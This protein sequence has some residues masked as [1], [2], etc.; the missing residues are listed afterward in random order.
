MGDTKGG[1]FDIDADSRPRCSPART[2]TAAIERR[3]RPA[4][5]QR[6]GHHGPAS[7]NMWIIDFGRRHSEQEAALYEAPFEYVRSTFNPSASK[8]R[9]VDRQWWLHVEPRPGCGRPSAGL[10]DTS[11]RPMPPSTGCSLA[12]ADLPDIALIAI[13]RG[14]RLH[15][16]RPP[17]ACPRA[18]G[19]R[20]T[21][22]QL[23]EVESGFRY[24][25]TTT[26]ETFPFPRPHG[27]AAR[28][29][30]GGRP[31]PRRAPR[32]LAQPARPRSRRPREAN[33]HQP[34]QPAPHLARPRPRRPSTP[35]SSP[36]TAGPHSGQAGASQSKPEGEPH[37]QAEAVWALA[38][39]GRGLSVASWVEPRL[40]YD[41]IRDAEY[42]WSVNSPTRDGAIPCAVG[43]WISP[44]TTTAK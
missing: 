4:V 29:S 10:A 35:P 23:R 39:R 7:R 34:L 25:P 40:K 44:R 38:G 28:E 41:M 42:A 43:P 26:F 14:R 18:L 2:P 9:T 20:D 30:R 24:T 8:R 36:P 12:A 17:L 22:T 27:R 37:L 32:R 16:R 21:G 31:P 11:R 1:P 5:G 6:P 19:A 3:R 13:A 33:P 15:V